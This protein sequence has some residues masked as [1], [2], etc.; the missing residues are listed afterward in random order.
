MMMKLSIF[1]KKKFR[2]MRLCYEHC[3][4][5]PWDKHNLKEKRLCSG[6]LDGCI[7]NI[8]AEFLLR[9]AECTE[10]NT[11]KAIMKSVN[12]SHL[13]RFTCSLLIYEVLKEHIGWERIL[14]RDMVP[15]NEH[16]KHKPNNSVCTIVLL[17]HALNWLEQD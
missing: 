11:K 2:E 9:S 13:Q 6:T 15:P 4:Q 3:K 8:L 7:R 12:K 17:S 16:T 14:I 5:L 1:L 10:K